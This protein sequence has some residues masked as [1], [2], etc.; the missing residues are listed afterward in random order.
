[1]AAVRLNDPVER[2][3]DASVATISPSATLRDAADAL[4]AGS[5]GLLVVVD[6][7]RVVGVLSERDLVVAMA[8]G[9][10]LAEE[11]IRDHVS[12]HPVGVDAS[13]SILDAAA[14]MVAAEVRHLTITRNGT[15]VGVISMRDVVAAVLEQHEQ[16]A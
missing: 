1:M 3:V 2:L 5:I 14:A 6:P 8:D 16:G 7:H 4:A 13:R 10:V 11:R 12:D 9:A 15:V